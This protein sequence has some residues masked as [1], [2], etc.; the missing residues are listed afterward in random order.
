[1][2][3]SIR[4]EAV[5]EAA[6]TAAVGRTGAGPWTRAP[7]QR[8]EGADTLCLQFATGGGRAGAAGINHLA[9]ADLDRFVEAFRSTFPNAS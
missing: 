4:W 8:R 7:K 5:E 9:E 2:I 6:T 3:V 1:M